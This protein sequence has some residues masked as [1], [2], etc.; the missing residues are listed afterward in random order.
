MNELITVKESY[1][2]NRP[3]RPVG[4]ETSRI[5]YFLVCSQMAVAALYL[6][7]RFLVIIYVRG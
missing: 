7:G 2:C 4:F 5:P 6:P 1:P 3:W